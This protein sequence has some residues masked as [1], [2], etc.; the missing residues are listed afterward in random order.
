MTLEAHRKYFDDYWMEFFID[1]NN[2]DILLGIKW[3]DS[4]D[5]AGNLENKCT[6]SVINRSIIT[7]H[8]DYYDAGSFFNKKYSFDNFFIR[9]SNGYLKPANVD[10]KVSACHPPTINEEEYIEQGSMILISS[11]DYIDELIDELTG[12]N[13][14]RKNSATKS[15]ADLLIGYRLTKDTLEKCSINLIDVDNYINKL[16][17]SS[18]DCFYFKT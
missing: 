10:L 5:I 4:K 13:L 8:I 14:F 11:G 6:K 2:C 17:F 1:E 16:D 12:S 9:I 7:P 18:D 3:I 15:F